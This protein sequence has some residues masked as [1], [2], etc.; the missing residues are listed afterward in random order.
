MLAA[1]CRQK[2]TVRALTALDRITPMGNA[3]HRQPP[4]PSGGIGDAAYT[5]RLIGG[6][7]CSGPHCLARIFPTVPPLIAYMQPPVEDYADLLVPHC[8]G[9]D[10]ALLG[11]T[12]FLFVFQ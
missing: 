11:L 6:C 5:I 12:V 4:T 3:E 7:P 10:F 2:V 9:I 8:I 1:L